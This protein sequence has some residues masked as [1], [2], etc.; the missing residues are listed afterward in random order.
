VTDWPPISEPELLERLA[1]DDEAFV[2]F[3]R[4]LSAAWGRRELDPAF[5][6]LVLGYPWER[7]G[8]SYVLRDSEVE[9]LDDLGADERAALVESFVAVRHPLLS[10][11]GNA[12]PSSLTRKFAH[13]ENEDDRSALVLTGEL[14]DYDIGPAAMVGPAGFMAATLFDSPGAKVRIGVVWATPAQVTQLTWTEI[15]YHLARLDDAHVV[16]TDA[17][18][19]HVFA[20]VHRRG[21]FC[22]DGEPVALAAVPATGRTAAA[23]TQEELLDRVAPMILAPDA[24]AEDLVRAVFDDYAAV[25]DRAQEIL[26]PRSRQLESAWTPYPVGA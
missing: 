19:H 17:E 12:A 9:L 26:W 10:Y 7:P 2:A 21:S 22:L 23:F 4:T 3:A 14:H 24:R 6:E 1:L 20:Y 13:F 15:P 5:L 18:L 25:A 11:G 8:A 16:M